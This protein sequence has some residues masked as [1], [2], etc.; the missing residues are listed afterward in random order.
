MFQM[1]AFPFTGK[2]LLWFGHKIG[3]AL[4]Q[5]NDFL[6]FSQNDEI[7]KKLPIFCS[8]NERE[9]NCDKCWNESLQVA[10]FHIKFELVIMINY[11]VGS[12]SKIAMGAYKLKTM[13]NI[14]F[15]DVVRMLC[16]IC[17]T[18]NGDK[19]SLSSDMQTNLLQF[20]EL[21]IFWPKFVPINCDNFMRLWKLKAI[22]SP[23][24]KWIALLI[25]QN[26][27]DLAMLIK[28]H[29]FN[30]S[31]QNFHWILSKTDREFAQ[32]ANSKFLNPKVVKLKL[33]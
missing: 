20:F 31:H 26:I 27:D 8:L 29:W 15:V 1:R 30:F 21:R 7:K 28:M 19:Y 22:I 3:K 32:K 24:F 4:Q 12:D 14:P 13:L 2:K 16:I 5:I 17:W 23:N 11:S 18:W 33:V 9:L 10:R 25:M 6:M